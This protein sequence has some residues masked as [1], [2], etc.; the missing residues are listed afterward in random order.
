MIALTRGGSEQH[1][2]AHIEFSKAGQQNVG[3][4]VEGRAV[5]RCRAVVPEVALA[6]ALCCFAL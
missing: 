3:L 1:V 6:A 4:V 2:V 5:A